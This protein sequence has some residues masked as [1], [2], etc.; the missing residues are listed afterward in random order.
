MRDRL[1][2]SILLVAAIECSA[3]AEPLPP[4]KPVQTVAKPPQRSPQANPCAAFGPGFVRMEGS[5][6]CVKLGGG[7]GIGI[8]AGGSSR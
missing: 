3:S 7:I 1:L 2:L 8:G 5:D 4:R 6:T